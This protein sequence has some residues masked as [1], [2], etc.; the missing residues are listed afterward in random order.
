MLPWATS[1]QRKQPPLIP[2][3]FTTPKIVGFELNIWS[4]ARDLNPGP[5][6]PESHDSSSKHVGFCVFLFDSSS[7]SARSV[8]ICTNL[9][10]DY[11]MKYYRMQVVE[12]GF[13]VIKR[14]D[15]PG[16]GRRQ[17]GECHAHGSACLS[18]KLP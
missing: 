6:G 1:S 2:G 8:Q 16:I 18:L 7:R 5:H 11:Y 9:Q 14:C 12:T 10:P 3:Q 13:S 15:R 17:Q 4:G